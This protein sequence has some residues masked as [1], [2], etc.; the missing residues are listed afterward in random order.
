MKKYKSIVTLAVALAFNAGAYARPAAVPDDEGNDC[1][2]AA[3]AG[4]SFGERMAA[5]RKA[6][7]GKAAKST[8][9]KA[10]KAKSAK[11]PKIPRAPK[12]ATIGD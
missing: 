6:S 5:A 1:I 12:L 3:P 8:G 11:A 4:Q 10:H 2:A 7:G 9:K